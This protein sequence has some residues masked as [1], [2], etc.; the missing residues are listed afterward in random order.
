MNFSIF[1][2]PLP[3]HQQLDD[4]KHQI[5]VP[6]GTSERQIMI[7]VVRFAF[8]NADYS[9]SEIRAQEG[10]LRFTVSD[11]RGKPSPKDFLLT[12]FTEDRWVLP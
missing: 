4:G 10:F 6:E 8:E 5:S 2:V 1:V 11:V 9:P 3:A 12:I 7:E